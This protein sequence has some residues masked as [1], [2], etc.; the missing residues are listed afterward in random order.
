VRESEKTGF[1]KKVVVVV[2]VPLLFIR[3]RRFSLPPFPNFSLL[4]LSLSTD[5]MGKFGII[6]T[7]TLS[8]NYI[9][10]FNFKPNKI[11]NINLFKCGYVINVIVFSYYHFHILSL[12]NIRLLKHTT[13]PPASP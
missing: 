11:L 4:S 9:Y 13:L 12:H 8:S 7:H 2:V 1:L 6:I 3:R 5:K 10:V